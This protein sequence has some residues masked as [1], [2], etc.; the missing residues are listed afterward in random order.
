MAN[1]YENLSEI[2]GMIEIQSKQK[3]PFHNAGGWAHDSLVSYFDVCTT[4]LLR[5]NYTRPELRTGIWK[6]SARTWRELKQVRRHAKQDDGNIVVSWLSSVLSG[7]LI[8]SIDLWWWGEVRWGE[9]VNGKEEKNWYGPNVPKCVSFEFLLIYHSSVI[10]LC[11]GCLSQIL[12]L[13]RGSICIFIFGF[14]IY[15]ISLCMFSNFSVSGLWV[16]CAFQ[17]YS[18]FEFQ[19]SLLFLC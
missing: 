12:D 16:H 18:A 19:N 15:E 6:I 7:N 4:P 17:F 11:E 14:V 10:G 5:R 9:L 3:T 2:F 13:G 8:H 1:S